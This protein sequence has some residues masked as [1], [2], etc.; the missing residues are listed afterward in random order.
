MRIEP[1]FKIASLSLLGLAVVILLIPAGTAFAQGDL[2]DD[3]A[4]LARTYAPVLYFHPV[5][6]FRP[7][8]VEVLVNSARLRQAR[9]NWFSQINVLSSISVADMLG[10]EDATYALDAWYGDEGTSDYRNYTA[11]RAYYQARLSPE[12]AGPPIVA[13]AHVVRDEDAGHVT[14]QYWLFYYYNDWFNK[15]EGDWELVQVVLTAAGE[16]EWVVLSQHHG[17]TRRAW[18]TAQVE[19][20]T[21]PVAY[22]ALGSHAN[23]FWGDE[24]YP[25]GVT[26]G[27]AR[28]EIMDRTGTAGRVIPD[29]ILI[30]DREQAAADPARWRGLEWISFGGRWG[31]IAP[32]SDFSGPYGPA[33]KGDQWERPY[34]WGMDQPLDVET[35]YANRL[36]VAVTGPAA[37]GAR[38]TLRY[39][40]GDS[41]PSAEA[42]GSLTLLHAD[43][44][45]GAA[46]VADVEVSF[47]QPYDLIATWPAAEASQVTRYRFDDVPADAPS[48]ATMTLRPDA[49]PR[50]VVEGA[51]QVVSPT[52]VEVDAAT[53][54]APDLVWLAGMLPASD[55]ARGVTISL[56]AGLLP[57]ILYV[58][59]IYWADRYEKEP[60]VMLAAAFLWGA[61]PALL[62]A[63]AVRL[64]FRIPIELLGPEAVEAVQAGLVA[65]LV[66]E[67]LKGLAVLFIALRYRLEF[68]NVLDG[69]IYGSMVGF[70]F[71]MI[72]NTVSYLGAFL[73]RGFSGLSSTIFVEGVLYGLNHALY[74]ALFGAGLGYV[75][76]AQRRWQRWVVPLAGFLSAVGAH[77]LHNLAI[78]HTIGLNPLT[79]VATW[80][81]VLLMVVVTVWSLRRQ[82]RWLVTELVDEVPD[83][84]YRAL[85]VRGGRFQSQWQALRRDGLAGWRRARRLHQ[86]CA[87]LAAKKAQSQRRPDAPRLLEEIERLRK[88]IRR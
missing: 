63:V 59:A 13:Y 36:R 75:R 72:G 10:Y 69:I 71:A 70:G 34:A 44:A 11:H 32:Q 82:R 61:I 1:G 74:T 42:L 22:V 85:T 41:L 87:E 88:E 67:A 12:A 65:P 58:G 19:E 29:V 9:R 57:T 46:I 8:P 3:D 16:P 68:D 66:E 6:V 23:Y 26:I 47:G 20:G 15:H 27:N 73:L 80:I 50:L 35:W 4:A 21:H 53:W 48:R 64:F 17:G 83:E 60:K 84:V 77:V 55:V 52:T 14:I 49:P 37:E 54:D 38:V 31:E 24:I 18:D 2:P 30:P 56:M 45:P 76:L 7:Q 78:R 79:V 5:E 25:N 33:D 81:G 43:P 40:N 51:S 28:L 39:A 62:V 86:Q